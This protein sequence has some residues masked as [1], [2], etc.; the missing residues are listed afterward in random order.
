MIRNFNL[1]KT[2]G[3]N[4]HKGITNDALQKVR[5]MEEYTRWI[6]NTSNIWIS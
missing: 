2:K 3:I 4:S 6:P 5:V 1:F